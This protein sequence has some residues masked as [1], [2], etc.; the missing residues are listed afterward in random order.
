MEVI[1]AI[2]VLWGLIF[3]VIPTFTINKDNLKE[4]E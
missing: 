3:L 2:L 4:E 1:G